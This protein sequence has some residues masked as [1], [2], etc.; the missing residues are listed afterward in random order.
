MKK[1]I[2]LTAKDIHANFKKHIAIIICISLFLT[3]FLTVLWYNGSFH[4]DISLDK[5]SELYE[6]QNKA[7]I[8]DIILIPMAVF[9]VV[10]SIIGIV[11]AMIYSFKQQENFLRLLRCIGFSKRKIG[12]FLKI[13]SIIIWLCSLI[14]SISC[15]FVSVNV[16]ASLSGMV[17]F[18]DILP[19]ILTA[20]ISLSVITITNAVL[21][22]AFFRHSPLSDNIYIPKHNRKSVFTLKKCWHKAFGRK[23]RLQ[24]AVCIVMIFMCTVMAV[25]GSF[26]P[27]FNARGTTWNDP[28]NAGDKD[29]SVFIAGGN[30]VSEDYYIQFPTGQGINKHKADMII[31]KYGLEVLNDTG[32]ELLQ[33]FFL[34]SE[35]GDNAML[36]YHIEL[37]KRDGLYKFSFESPLTETMIKS[38]GGTPQDIIG[39]LPVCWMSKKTLFNLYSPNIDTQK[40]MNGDDIVAPDNKCQVGDTFTVLIPVFYN[41]LTTENINEN[42]KFVCKKMTVSSV[43][44]ADSDNAP[45]IFSQEYLFSVNSTLNYERLDLSANHLSDK[46]KIALDTELQALSETSTSLK[47]LN[48]DKIRTEFYKQVNT[49]TIQL[50]VSVGM[51]VVLILSALIMSFYVQIQEN[52]ES[53]ILLHIIGADWKTIHKLLRKEIIRLLKTGIISGIIF[54]LSADIFFS[55]TNYVQTWDIFLKYVLPVS[56]FEILALYISVYMILN[57]WEYFAQKQFFY[58]KNKNL[59]EIEL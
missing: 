28:D 26:I 11:S 38:A 53:C 16:I 47:Y 31:Q 42:L 50:A 45:L 9:F 36:K 1:Y 8:S 59:Q 56:S 44:H 18:F 49:Q 7:K 13:R 32:G 6:I 30:T 15:S 21:L 57:H 29:Y 14:L 3:A 12:I 39:I 51:F 58:R 24:N 33:P 10:T 41:D 5:S 4:Y 20:L 40:F 23:F 37:S 52:R 27:L 17:C 22:K 35:N 19:L 34:T 2:Y 25:T 43:Y 54:G 48:Y 46:E 55:L